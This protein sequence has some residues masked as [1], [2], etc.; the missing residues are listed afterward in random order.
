MNKEIHS[1]NQ[2]L[3]TADAG[4]YDEDED[5]YIH[6]EKALT[7]RAW[8][9]SLLGKIIDYK[10]EHQRVL[11]E[12]VVPTLQRFLPQDIVM[13]NVLPFLELPSNSFE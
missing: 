5:E 10:A 9:S 1:I 2:I 7:I 8:I 12:D 13:N 6:G 11:E 4:Y 3:P